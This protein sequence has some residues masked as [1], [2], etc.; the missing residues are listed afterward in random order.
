MRIVQ[1][2]AYPVS[3]DCIGGG[4]EASVYGLAQEQSLAHEV[5]VFDVPRIGGRK[6]S[7]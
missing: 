2:G 5:H 4:V 6:R 7:Q 3:S 1:I